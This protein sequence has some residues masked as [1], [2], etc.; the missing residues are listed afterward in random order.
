[1]NEPFHTRLIYLIS[2]IKLV[3]HSVRFP[4]ENEV[5]VIDRL[6]FILLLDQ[7]FLKSVVIVTLLIWG[8]VAMDGSILLALDYDMPVCARIVRGVPWYLHPGTFWFMSLPVFLFQVHMTLIELAKVDGGF[9]RP[10]LD[11]LASI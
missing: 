8:I 3:V 10:L 9:I 1:M 2:L 6:C 5:S 4:D 11:L 7:S